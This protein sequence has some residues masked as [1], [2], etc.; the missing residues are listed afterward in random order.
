MGYQVNPVGVYWLLEDTVEQAAAGACSY[1]HTPTHVPAG[2]LG[3]TL[4]N[5]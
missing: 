3:I 1:M 2:T 4:D 5:R